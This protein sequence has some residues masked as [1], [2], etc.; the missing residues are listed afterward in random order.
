LKVCR[1]GAN[2]TLA[3]IPLKPIKLD[4]LPGMDRRKLAEVVN[5]TPGRWTATQN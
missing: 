3:P 1:S 5:L 2:K 4:V